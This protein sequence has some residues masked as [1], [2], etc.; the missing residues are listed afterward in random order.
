MTCP[1]HEQLSAFADNELPLA[2]NKRIAAHLAD[3]PACR[4]RHEEIIRLQSELAALASPRLGFDLAAR[5]AG[6]PPPSQAARG[7]GRT[8][9]PVWLG[10]G[11]SIAVSL[12]AGIWLGSLLLATPAGIP[13]SLTVDRV[14]GPIPPGGL[15]AAPELCKL[16][17]GA[18]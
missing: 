13:P 3:C 5:Y 9:W 12:S 15:C 8:R 2:Q 4:G 10:G 17:G 7:S 1:L 14:F 18:R 16:P 11:T 6:Y